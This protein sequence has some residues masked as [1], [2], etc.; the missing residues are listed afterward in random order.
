[1]HLSV[2]IMMVT[3]QDNMYI[4]TNYKTNP[5]LQWHKD[6]IRLALPFIAEPS[7]PVNRPPRTMIRDESRKL[8]VSLPLRPVLRRL[9]VV[10]ERPSCGSAA[11]LEFLME[12]FAP[13]TAQMA[14]TSDGNGVKETAK[15]GFAVDKW[16]VWGWWA[17]LCRLDCVFD[18]V[19]V[20]E[21]AAVFP[22]HFV[23]VSWHAAAIAVRKSRQLVIDASVPSNLLYDAHIVL[24]FVPKDLIVA[25][26]F[27][28][29]CLQNHTARRSIVVCLL[30]H[31]ARFRNFSFGRF[32][33]VSVDVGLQG[34]LI[35]VMIGVDGIALLVVA[36]IFIPD[37]AHDKRFDP[38][39]RIHSR[40]VRVDRA[41]VLKV[42][43]TFFGNVASV[44]HDIKPRHTAMFADDSIFTVPFD[45]YVH[46]NKFGVVSATS[47]LACRTVNVVEVFLGC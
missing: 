41:A 24:A 34:P 39:S 7:R 45:G 9:I 32:F 25:R 15:W 11:A 35:D 28:P 23:L 42:A 13:V 26:A 33:A 4:Y 12:T 27:R 43:S 3:W 19:F 29:L 21:A 1:M 20:G 5:R 6:T 36:L 44:H 46:V 30:K 37:L 2:G 31:I 14:G 10:F 22:V 8:A 18:A 47:Q 16:C 40:I 17:G 38:E